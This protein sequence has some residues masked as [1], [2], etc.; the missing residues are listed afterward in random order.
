MEKKLLKLKY[1]LLLFLILKFIFFY[2]ISFAQNIVSHKRGIIVDS[3]AYGFFSPNSLS[4]P[5]FKYDSYMS[6][7]VLD[8]KY[9]NGRN[10][11]LLAGITMHHK[12]KSY[13]ENRPLDTLIPNLWI[14]ATHVVLLDEMK[15]FETCWPFNHIEFFD[16]YQT[17]ILT[18]NSDGVGYFE[19]SEGFPEK[20]KVAI[21][22]KDDII[23]VRKLGENDYFSAI[24]LTDKSLSNL[25]S[26]EPESHISL[27]EKLG[28]R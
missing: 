15:R 3:N 13:E 23:G 4:T 10:Y 22:R 7:D 16:G 11:F 12:K 9:E 19:P 5:I 18:L 6:V 28:C 2:E 1:L 25:K 26:I 24:F 27:I 8:V 14:E 17:L 21:Y 20:V